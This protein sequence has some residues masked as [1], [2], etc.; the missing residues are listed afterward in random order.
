MYRDFRDDSLKSFQRETDLAFIKKAEEGATRK[1]FKSY[2][3]SDLY[4][5]N[6]I[7]RTLSQ[8]FSLIEAKNGQSAIARVL[9]ETEIY[10]ITC[11]T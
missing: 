3:H 5:K 2:L 8:N 7:F 4:V 9:D 1:F 6:F 10:P 11:A